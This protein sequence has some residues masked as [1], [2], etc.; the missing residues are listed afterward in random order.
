MTIVISTDDN[1]RFQTL[2][3]LK[4]SIS[5]RLDRT[6]GDDDLNDFIY[7]AEREMERILP[8]A[9]RELTKIGRASCR[10][11]VSSPV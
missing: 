7:L 5:A 4:E 6:F 9:A 11:R 10:E 3:G 2:A 8:V 1:I